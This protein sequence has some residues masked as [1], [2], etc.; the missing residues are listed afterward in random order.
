MCNA[1]AQGDP[2]PTNGWSALDPYPY[3]P[4]GNVYKLTQDFE[5]VVDGEFISLSNALTDAADNLVPREVAVGFKVSRA[6]KGST[7]AEITIHLNSDM[8]SFSDSDISNYAKRAQIVE[9][10]GAV[11]S[12]ILDQKLELYMALGTGDISSQ[13]FESEKSELMQLEDSLV[14][15]IQI[16]GLMHLNT[17]EWG[18]LYSEY[19]WT[20]LPK[21]HIH[22]ENFHTRKGAIKEHESYLLGVNSIVGEPHTYWLD[23][24]LVSAFWG[25][26]REDTLIAWDS[27][28]YFALKTE[29]GNYD[30]HDDDDCE[31]L[32][33]LLGTP[34]EPTPDDK[35]K[36]LLDEYEYVARGE[37]VDVPVP[38]AAELKTL[39]DG[40]TQ[41][42]FSVH[43]I[44]KG[45]PT[46]SI[47]VKINSDMLFVPGEDRSRY[48][49]RQK[50]IE[51]YVD[52]MRPHRQ[53]EQEVLGSFAAG[54]IDEQTWEAE[55]AR[56]SALEQ[57]YGLESG[58]TDLL[59][60]RQVSSWLGSTFYERGGRIE[61]TTNYLVGVNRTANGEPVYL[62]GELPESPSRIYWGAEQ[63]EILRA[64]D[65]LSREHGEN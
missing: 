54:A 23:E 6:Y 35:A 50:I 65:R 59:S 20:L 56:V 52:A 49:K 16:P 25:E 57:Q 2:I 61:P 64:L 33:Q 43:Q 24:S 12:P 28:K 31:K 9:E 4:N 26:E 8:L 40:E 22:G 36:A 27:P 29:L 21:I 38:T 62:L 18:S 17:K 37:F 32:H 58:L 42:R 55:Y 13:D 34:V 60:G 51:H 15:T 44:F 11:I 53:R 48:A 30:P 7:P 1:R 63:E 45:D 3:S 19:I 10:Y 5:V 46:E 47:D 14:D 39:K 41:V